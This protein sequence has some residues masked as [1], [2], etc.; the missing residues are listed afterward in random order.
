MLF[1]SQARRQPS[2]VL[3]AQPAQQVLQAVAVQL[4]RQGQLAFLAQQAPLVQ[5][6]QLALR[7]RLARMV[8]QGLPDR[9]A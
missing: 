8:Q 9:L 7:V 1:R 3:Q 2:Q 5:R 6:G 4:G